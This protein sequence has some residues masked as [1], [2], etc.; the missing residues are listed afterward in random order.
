MLYRDNA[1]A[2]TP[3]DGAIAV[4]RVAAEVPLFMS[5]PVFMSRPASRDALTSKLTAVVT[6]SAILS[7]AAV[8]SFAL[9]GSLGAWEG[10]LLRRR[11]PQEHR[12]KAGGTH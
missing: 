5:R 1:C 12:R 6:V 3:H 4:R 11:E 9:Q 7:V 10:H 2:K 8:R